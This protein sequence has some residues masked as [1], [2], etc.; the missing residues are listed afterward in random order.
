MQSE[1]QNN[2]N[3]AGKS[4]VPIKIKI[5]EKYTGKL[6]DYILDLED[7]MEQLKRENKL[8]K[9]KLLGA[10]TE[11]KEYRLIQ[12]T[13][14]VAPQKSNVQELNLLRNALLEANK[15]NSEQL[16]KIRRQKESNYNLLESQKKYESLKKHLRLL[17]YSNAEII[18]IAKNKDGFELQGQAKGDLLYLMD[19]IKTNKEL[20]TKIKILEKKVEFLQSKD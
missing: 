3:V 13:Q 8:L 7:E 19:T 9:E 2:I 1:E 4:F 20:A 14:T 16:E 5:L 6:S 11:L 15:I 12:F 18:K 10:D 17:N